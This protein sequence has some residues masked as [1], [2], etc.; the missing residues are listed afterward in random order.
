MNGFRTLACAAMM[1]VPSFSALHAQGDRGDR[2]RRF[3]DERRRIDTTVPFKKNGEISL[4]VIVGDIRV[5]GWAKDEVRIVATSMGSPIDA[6]ITSESIALDADR[7]GRARLELNVP[8]GVSIDVSSQTGTIIISG[9]KGPVSVETQAATV[10]V[11]DVAGRGDF[12]TAAGRLTLQRLEGRIAVATLGGAVNIT[13]IR[14]ALEMESTGGI[15]S[16]DR[17]DL[18]E[19]DFTSVGDAF[20]FSGTLAAQ[21][22]HSIE[23]VSGAITLRFPD[24][25]GASIEFDTFSGQFHP[26]DFPVTLQPN[27]GTG[28]GRS[29]ERQPFTINGG[30]ARIQIDTHSGDVFLRKIGVPERKER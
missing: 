22:R 28:R 19:L 6:R 30:G 29:V 8:I 15:M 17:A 9:T 24:N 1:L 20:N 14:G 12:E 13:E 21:G 3:G 11:S 2:N 27:S 4:E 18:T 10:E 26:I 16:V 7:G 23:T 5:T 25:F